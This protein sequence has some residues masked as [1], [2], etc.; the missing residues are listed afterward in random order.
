[1]SQQLFVHEDV[2]TGV[3]SL[4]LHTM[5]GHPFE[6]HGVAQ[7]VVVPVLV[8]ELDEL[9]LSS[10]PH[11]ATPSTITKPR[12]RVARARRTNMGVPPRGAQKNCSD[13]FLGRVAGHTTPAPRPREARPARPARAARVGAQRGPLLCESP[14]MSSKKSAPPSKRT[15]SAPA[16]AAAKKAPKRAVKAAV[17]P[18]AKRAAKPAVKVR[19]KASPKADAKRE[20][21]T[22]PTDIVAGVLHAIGWDPDRSD[23]DDGWTSFVTHVDDGVVTVATVARVLEDSSR[24]V[25]YAILSPRARDEVRVEVVDFLMRA[26]FGMP[27]GNF[28]MDPVTG[29]VRFKI[30]IDF[31]GL[32]LPPLLVRNA[33]LDAGAAIENYG[34]SIARVLHGEATAAEAIAEAEGA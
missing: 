15:A 24:F 13:A 7:D 28:E 25:L 12:V 23:D 19:A 31:C 17:K 6:L 11:A 22:S 20:V 26:N 14:A 33:I 27:D 1:V 5:F 3:P 34:P 9:D 18:A 2:F 4:Q 10:E 8:D 16:R 21:A 30:G 29:E 32:S